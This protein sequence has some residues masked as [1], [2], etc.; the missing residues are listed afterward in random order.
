L[1]F[2]LDLAQ[3]WRGGVVV[4]CGSSSR[5]KVKATLRLALQDGAPAHAGGRPGVVAGAVLFY[6]LL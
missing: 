1:A 3:R 6:L 5:K 2:F 4:L